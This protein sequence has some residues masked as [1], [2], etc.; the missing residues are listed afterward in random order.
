MYLHLGNE[1]NIRTDRIIGIFNIENTSIG[2]PTRDFLKIAEQEGRVVNVDYEMPKS[3][4]VTDEGGY[5]VYITQ[6]SA[7][8]LTKRLEENYSRDYM[9]R[10]AIILKE[11]IEK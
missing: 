11:Q 1:K 3:F 6:I 5:T 4:V 10:K 8:T 7:A 9:G 2:R